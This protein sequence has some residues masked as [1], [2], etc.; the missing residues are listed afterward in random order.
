MNKGLRKYRAW[1][2]VV[3]ED[4]TTREAVISFFAD[5]FLEFTCE[6]INGV[7]L[8]SASRRWPGREVRVG[9]SWRSGS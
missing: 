6:G 9:N 4:G 8:K 5:P 2:G 3:G 1:V 7:A